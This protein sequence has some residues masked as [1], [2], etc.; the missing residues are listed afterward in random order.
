MIKL[1]L[2]KCFWL[3]TIALLATIFKLYLISG[4]TFSPDYHNFHDQRL[5]VKLADQLIQGHWLGEFNSL[6]LTKGPFYPIWLA[7]VHFLQVPLML[8]DHLLYILACVLFAFALKPLVKNNASLTVIY[9]FLLFNPASFSYNYS[10][11]LMSESIYSALTMMVVSSA[12]GIFVRSLCYNKTDIKWAIGLGLSLAAFWLTRIGGVW[13]MPFIFVL[14]FFII[15]GKNPVREITKAILIPLL[16]FTI[17]AGGVAYINWCYYGVFATDDLYSREFRSAYG[18]L[19]RVKQQ[20]FDITTPL[21]RKAR[22][23]I[24]PFSPSLT[25]LEPHLESI[26]KGHI[27]LNNQREIKGSNVFQMLRWAVDKAGYYHTYNQAAGF[28]NNLSGEINNACASGKLDCYEK[29]QGFFPAWRTGNTY[30]FFQYS[31]NDLLYLCQFTNINPWPLQGLSDRKSLRIF[32]TFTGPKF[33][34]SH[35]HGLT[36]NK[37]SMKDKEKISM[38]EAIG[39]CWQVII[40]PLSLLAVLGYLF[41]V[42]SYLRT[43]TNAL[44]LIIASGIL[45]AFLTRIIGVAYLQ[46]TLWFESRFLSCAQPLLLM[47]IIFVLTAIWTRLRPDPLD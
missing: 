15:I 22:L 39:R 7:M 4:Q 18:Q 3:V 35:R 9:V 8:A 34:F 5:F 20:D 37:I 6:T 42:F 24:L 43:K 1:K 40:V 27:Y 11:K 16:I 36:L 10:L 29:T 46:T 19:L 2:N 12:I 23:T 21:P 26:E 17:L 44:A 45:T 47:F 25:L 14:I 32:N 31:C 38:L 13:I 30:N 41:M 28:Y 33:I